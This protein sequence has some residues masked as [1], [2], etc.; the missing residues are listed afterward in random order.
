[1]ATSKEII[2]GLYEAFGRGDAETV[3]G[4]LD[5]SVDWKEAEGG[6]LATDNPYTG[7]QAV[8][9]GVFAP[10]LSEL[11]DFRVSPHLFVAEGGEVVAFGRYTGTHRESGDP[12]DAQFT[13]HWSVKDGK[14]VAFQQYTDTAQWSRLYGA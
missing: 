7:P 1:V 2:I 9:G 4:M 6:P 12:L 5:E 10:L 3:L 14:I 11:E 13:H 8:A